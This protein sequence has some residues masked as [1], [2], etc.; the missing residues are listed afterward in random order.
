MHP[1][2]VFFLREISSYATP[3]LSKTVFTSLYTPDWLSLR[4][5]PEIPRI[6]MGSPLSGGLDWRRWPVI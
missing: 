4:G 2:I 5:L 3:V 1:E 6:F